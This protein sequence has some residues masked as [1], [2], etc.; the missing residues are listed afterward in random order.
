MD[1]ALRGI[2]KRFGPV[3]ANEAVD[4]DILGG[5]V[6]ALLGEN[7]AGKS[8]LMKIL[9]GFYKADAGGIA[10]DGLPVAFGSP[11]EAM[12]AGIGM[13]FQQFSLIPALSVREN[14]MLAWP[15]A[16]W[17]LR[18]GS[19]AWDGMLE[20]LA[21]MA[22]DLDPERR[23]RDLA[24]GE[25][26][27]VELVKVLNLEARLV[28]L[29]EPTSVL[30]PTETRRL[31]EQVRLLATAGHAVVFITHK[32]EDVEACADRVAVMRHG[33]L[34]DNVSAAGASVN[35]LVSLMMGQGGFRE[36]SPVPAPKPAAPWLWIKGLSAREGSSR[37][38]DID[39]KLIPGEI[40]GI[41]GVAGNGQYLLAETL[42]GRHAPDSGEVLLDGEPMTRESGFEPD[43][44]RVAYIP[45]QPAVNGIAGDLDL[46]VNLA[47]KQLRK[48]PFFPDWK[49]LRTSASDLIRRFDVRPTDPSRSAGDLS[50][51]NIQKLVIARELSGK[52]AFIVACYPT[53]GL[54]LSA[55]KAVYEALFRHAAEGACVIWISEDLDDLL[56]YAHRIAVLSRGRIA[57][58]LPV[59]AADRERV[60]LLMAGHGGEGDWTLAR[61]RAAAETARAA[62]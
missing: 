11:K 51:G 6:L 8:T 3:L 18:R 35:D 54:D 40:V 50:G 17:F 16:P 38:Q 29:D 60:G 49:A 43:D 20:R 55:A 22:P 57:G 32:F 41:A 56:A 36:A 39:L 13:V 10:I 1:I 33:R 23:V 53:M 45:E 47:L 9:Y 48:L 26:Q 15:K 59:A 61:A 52:P 62:A 27:L 25:R 34:V 19:R 31:W 58:V 21:A 2:T 12:A 46:S 14:L 24:V 4:L 5:Q 44:E 7:G 42:A 28:I 30:T 37:I